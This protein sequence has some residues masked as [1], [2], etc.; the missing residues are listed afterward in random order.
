MAKYNPNLVKIHRSYT[1]GELAQVFG[2]HK[3]TVVTWVKKGLPCL[4]EQRPFLILGIDAKAFLQAQRAN[5]KQK[6][7]PN[8]FYCVRCKVPVKVAENFVEYTPLSSK[9]GRLSGF[10]I[11]CESVVNKFIAYNNLEAYSHIF[12]I[13][14]PRGLEH[15]KDTD[16]PLL[17][18]DFSQ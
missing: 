10:C 17:N 11:H 14:K 15:I 3:N 18:S 5:R 13:E 2:V 7:K 8:E 9:K 1:Y 6:C 16:N 12:A 4:Q